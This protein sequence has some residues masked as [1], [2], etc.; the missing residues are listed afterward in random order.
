[1]RSRKLEVLENLLPKTFDTL[2]RHYDTN[3]AVPFFASPCISYTS[4]SGEIL[5]LIANNMR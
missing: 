3:K 5:F 4:K 1:M 2:S